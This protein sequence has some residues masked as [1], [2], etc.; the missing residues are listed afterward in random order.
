PI[1]MPLW[2]PLIEKLLKVVREDSDRKELIHYA[3]SCVREG[4]LPRA[5]SVLRRADNKHRVDDELKTTF[6]ATRLFD[7]RP[8]DSKKQEMLKRLNALASLP[9]AGYVTSNYD[10]LITDH[11][12]RVGRPCNNVCNTPYD[13]L[14][15]ALKS[16]DRPFFIHLHG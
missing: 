16:S 6:D 15:R 1:D 12:L 4:Q 10:T 11:L 5:A 7:R 9:W 14:A 2:R 3:E 13:N 8:N